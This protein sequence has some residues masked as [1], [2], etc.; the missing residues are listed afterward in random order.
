MEISKNEEETLRAVET[1]WPNLNTHSLDSL[2]DKGLIYT[3][4]SD[5]GLKISEEGTKLLDTLDGA[6]ASTHGCIT[7]DSLAEAIFEAKRHGFT[8]SSLVVYK[9]GQWTLRGLK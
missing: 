7:R 5:Y 2:L 1:C 6:S 8:I 4:W 3:E 9:H